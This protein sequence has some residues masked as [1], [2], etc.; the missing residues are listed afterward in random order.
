M[1]AVDQHH[2]VLRENDAGVGFEVLSDVDV[3]AVGELRELRAEILRRCGRVH[4]QSDE[5]DQCCCGLDSHE[6]PPG[7]WRS[8]TPAKLSWVSGPSPMSDDR[9]RV[10]AAA[11]QADSRRVGKGALHRIAIKT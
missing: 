4:H 1:A 9:A 6:G 3:D 8:A 10:L 11:R 5:R 2:S 7:I